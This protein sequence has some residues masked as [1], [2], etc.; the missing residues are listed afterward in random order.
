M[1]IPLTK[2][3][4]VQR[5]VYG[6]FDETPDRAGEICDYATAKAE[7]QAWS[8][9]MSKASDGENLGNIRE[10]HD[11]KKAAGKLVDIVYDDLGKSINFVA[12]IV[13]DI[14]WNKVMERIYTGF[15][16]GGSYA[17]RWG[18][19]PARR[20]TPRVGELSIVDM[21]CNPSATFTM[22]KADGTEEEV[23]FVLAKAYEP[24]NEATI[25]RAEKMAKTAG[26]N[27]KP[28]D[29]VAK[30]RA[31]L[32]AERAN[33]ELAKLHAGDELEPEA[34]ASEPAPSV[35]DKLNAVL[36]KADAVIESG[37]APVLMKSIFADAPFAEPT[38]DVV[39][40]I[41][42][43]LIKSLEAVEII[44][45]AAIPLAKGLYGIPEVATAMRGFA[46]IAQ[47]VCSEERW[48]G[49]KTS[50]LPQ[51]AIDIL[52][53]M[54]TFLIAMI[55]EEVAELLSRTK[56][57]VG[58]E[59][60]LVI[61]GDSMEL[62]N[63]IVDLVKAN[64]ALMEKAGKRNSKSDAATIQAMHDNAVKLG[65]VCDEDVEKIAS[66]EAGNEALQKAASSALPRIEKLTE[67]VEA[68]QKSATA[69]NALVVELREKV[70]QLEAQ[71]ALEKG[72]I[73]AP[74]DKEGD[75]LEQSQT[76]LTGDF[77]TDLAKM[78]PRERTL[79]VLNRH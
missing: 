36:E 16:P 58:D 10:Q 47:D 39:L 51:Q 8:D 50:P 66:L 77:V 18:T 76:K 15:S 11:M 79:A 65:A 6:R 49:D 61:E 48:E 62:A 1:F 46:W 25:A 54:K 4:A 3:D 59:I 17:K 63:Q 29:F 68:L 21:P 32:I 74:I 37:T 57:E 41:G 64:E 23:E 13:D 45:T 2:V 34:P 69:S 12:K 30:A 33:D 71:P 52:A 35:A 28:T 24:G 31:D 19:P 60:T 7:F 27:R 22:V 72:A 20:Y 56:A 26:A 78:S 75:G 9:G 5:L 42:A 70:A 43:D 55:E 40:V 14:A 53:A 67:S 73:F 44:R 38:A